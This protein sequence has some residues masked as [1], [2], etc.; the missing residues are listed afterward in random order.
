MK[1]K[2]SVPHGSKTVANAGTSC[3]VTGPAMPATQSRLPSGLYFR[4]I[5]T[6]LLTM[7]NVGFCDATFEMRH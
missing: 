3:R 6:V 4:S 7:L 2:E 1:K 5:T